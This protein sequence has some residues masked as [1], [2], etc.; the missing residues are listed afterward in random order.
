MKSRSRYQ[1]SRLRSG[2]RWRGHINKPCNEPVR[3]SIET[4]RL[5]LRPFESG[6]VEAAFTWFGD[7]IVM[8]FTPAGPDASPQQTKARQVP[9]TPDC[10]WLQQVDHIASRLGTSDRGWGVARAKGVR[11]D[12]PRCPP[13]TIVLGQG[14]GDG[15][16]IS[17]GA[18]CIQ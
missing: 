13:R 3:T 8:R 6:D 12:R 17:L 7:P 10:A 4:S 15:S 5:I 2:A 1:E 16:G 9:R 11:L 18:R 14:F